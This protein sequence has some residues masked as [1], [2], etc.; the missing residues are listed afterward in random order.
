MLRRAA[1]LSGMLGRVVVPNGMRGRAAVP[2]GIA[3]LAV[4]PSGMLGRASGLYG[5]HAAVGGNT[6]STLSNL[7][8]CASTAEYSTPW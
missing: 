5:D 7:A 8:V 1:V 3:P 6:T 2:N 4:V